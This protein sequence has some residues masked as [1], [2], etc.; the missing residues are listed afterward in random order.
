MD[1]IDLKNYRIIISS[2]NAV[3]EEDSAKERLLT[4]EKNAAETRRLRNKYR[5][6]VRTEKFARSGKNIIINW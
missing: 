6:K 2:S 5:K 4:R 3:I 1:K